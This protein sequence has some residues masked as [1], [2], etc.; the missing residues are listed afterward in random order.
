V[1]LIKLAGECGVTYWSLFRGKNAFLRY[2]SSPV[3]EGTHRVVWCPGIKNASGRKS[4]GPISAREFAKAIIAGKDV[5]HTVSV[6]V[7]GSF[8]DFARD[9]YKELYEIQMDLLSRKK[10]DAIEFPFIIGAS[11]PRALISA[12]G[13]VHKDGTPLTGRDF[14]EAHE[15]SVF[16]GV[17]EWMFLVLT[18][19]AEEDPI[20]D[21]PGTADF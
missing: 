11:N 4:M 20:G 15:S 9:V 6:L 16:E 3:V 1:W 21:G 19:W 12:L 2:V 14:F 10:I 18:R 8:G 5:K 7:F 13:R 17:H